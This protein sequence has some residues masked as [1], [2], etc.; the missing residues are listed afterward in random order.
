MV[1]S[2]LSTL[3][4]LLVNLKQVPL[5]RQFSGGAGGGLENSGSFRVMLA[6]AAFLETGH[7]SRLTRSGLG[8]R[9]L[10]QSS[11]VTVTLWMKYLLY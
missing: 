8:T 7:V 5:S 2:G 1:V 6:A 3:N 10:L 9:Q 11:F 4:S